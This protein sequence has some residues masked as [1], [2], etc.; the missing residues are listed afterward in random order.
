VHHMGIEEPRLLAFA[1]AMAASG[2]Q[3]LTPELAALTDYRVDPSSIDLIGSSARSFAKSLHRKVGAL[4]I[5]FGGGLALLAAADPQYAPYMRFVMTIGAHDDLARVAGFYI[6]DQIERP[7]G[8]TLYMKAN[9][10]GPLVLIY[11]HM[12]D[13][14]P[15]ADLAT[16]RNAMRLL[17]WEKVD[18]SRKQAQ[19]LSPPSQREMELMYNGDKQALAPEL[20]KVVERHRSDMAAVSPHGRVAALQMPVFLLHGA[21]DNVVPPAELLWL[22]QDVPRGELRAALVS[23]AISHASMEDKVSLADQLRLVDFMAMV[24]ETEDDQQSIAAPWPAGIA[25]WADR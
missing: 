14:F 15:A 24:L 6:T 20:Q 2:V 13:F 23:P 22:E 7:D 21:G 12:E 19:L 9:N 16:T 1:R 8:S 18:E 10:Y 5:S 4:G 11:S 25:R 17:L 3:V